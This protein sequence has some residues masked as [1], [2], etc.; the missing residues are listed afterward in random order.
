MGVPLHRW[1]EQ[2][3]QPCYP[4]SL[5]WDSQESHSFFRDGIAIGKQV[6]VPQDGSWLTITRKEVQA[7]ASVPDTYGTPFAWQGNLPVPYGVL[8]LCVGIWWWSIA[9]QGALWWRSGR[10]VGSGY[11][12][13]LVV[14]CI[15]R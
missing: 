2:T 14:R 5:L 13:V 9:I 7:T 11:T 8:N 3:A 6:E 15:S 4:T 1:Q 10:M 12:T